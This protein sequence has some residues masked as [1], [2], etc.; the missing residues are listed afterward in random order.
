MAKSTK[1]LGKI[2]QEPPKETRSNFY[3]CRCGIAYG[4]QKGFFPVSHSPM[5][6]GSGYLPVCNECI[7]GLYDDYRRTLGD[8][9]A[10]MHRICMK[11][12]LYWHEGIYGMVE[13]SAGVHSRIRNYIGKTNLYRYLDKTYD[14]TIKEGL[15]TM[16]TNIPP[17]EELKAE[18]EAEEILPEI[19]DEVKLFW[20]P[21]YGAKMYY[22]L[23][24]RRKYWMSKYPDVALD[25][26]TE[27]II[28]QICNLEIDI[29]HDRAAGKTIDK[30]VNV[31]NTLLGSANLRPAQQQKT[32]DAAQAVDRR[33]F[34]VLIHV[35]ENDRPIPEPDLEFKDVDN[36]VRYISIWFLGHLSKMLGIKN[37]Y[38]KLY[39]DEMAKRRVERPEFEDEDDEGLFNE[40]FASD[41]PDDGVS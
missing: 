29:N 2:V 8:D 34:G 39:E 5:Y 32:E 22:E 12:D 30:S 20:G 17:P 3:C 21:G 6:R 40:I 38:S 13:K 36:I 33:P 18:E 19:S 23:E 25:I 41:S 10:A 16:V 1:R 31:L 35:R 7:E 28:R 24:E 9:K 14:D 27:A 15:S 26:G 11:L 4:R 37:A